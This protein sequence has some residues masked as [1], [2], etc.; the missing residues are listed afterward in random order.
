[1]ILPFSSLLKCFLNIFFRVAFFSHFIHDNLTVEFLLEYFFSFRSFFMQFFSQLYF[2]GMLL[3][4]GEILTNLASHVGF[5]SHYLMQAGALL[6]SCTKFQVGQVK[7]LALGKEISQNSCNI[8]RRH[9]FLSHLYIQFSFGERYNG[10]IAHLNSLMIMYS[11]QIGHPLKEFFLSSENSNHSQK[12]NFP[13]HASILLLKLL[14]SNSC[15]FSCIFAALPL[16]K[17]TTPLET[18]NIV[19]E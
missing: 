13:P 12:H 2:C 16:S 7:T 19:L 5:Y 14:H 4:S 10:I 17:S 11:R 18:R 3:P 9:M 1:M 6:A 15:Y 8:F